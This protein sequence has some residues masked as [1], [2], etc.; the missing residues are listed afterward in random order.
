MAD[1]FHREAQLD[2]QAFYYPLGFPL[3]LKTNSKE[4][5]AAADS[6]WSGASKLF[7]EPPFEL[8]V[9]VDPGES[10]PAPPVYR[11]QA[12]LMTAIS[13]PDNFGVCDYTQNLA[14]C[15]LTESASKMRDFVVYWYLKA[16]IN[17]AF[18]QL[19]LTPIHGACIALEGRGVLICGA[20]GSGKTTLAYA[21]ARKGWTYISDNESWLVRGGNL[22]VGDPRSIRFRP[23]AVKLFPEL[24]PNQQYPNGKFSIQMNNTA[25]S[26]QIARIVYLSKIDSLLDEIPLYEEHVREEHRKSLERLCQLEPIDLRYSSLDEAESLLRTSISATVTR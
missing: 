5:L 3:Q 7:D 13:G 8:R 20:S 14:F 11:S 25:D 1:P 4:I 23:D 26:C 9:I 18:T 15:R 17:Y 19:Y 12:H 24:I 21:C 22:L 10:I 6:L 16:L 2:L